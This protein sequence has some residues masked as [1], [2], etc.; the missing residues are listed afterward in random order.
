MRLVA[1]QCMV[2]LGFAA[3]G[4]QLLPT[5]DALGGSTRSVPD[6]AFANT[7]ALH[8]LN[9]V[10]LLEPYLWQ[11]RVVG[12]N[13]HELGLYVGAVPILLCVWL[14][15]R[16]EYPARLLPF[17]RAILVLAVVSLLLAFG[18]AG[19]LYRLQ[20]L[21]P[22]V[23]QFRFP[24]RAIVLF[25]LCLAAGAATALAAMGHRLHGPDPQSLRRTDRVLAI[26]V[27][28]SVALAIAGPYLWPEFV[29]RPL[30]IWCG[31]ALI[32][33][34]AILIALTERRVRGAFA[35]LAI[36]TVAD[37]SVYGLSYSVWNH[38]D[39]LQSFI[40]ASPRPPG[41]RRP[42]RGCSRTRQPAARA[43]ACCCRAYIES[44]ATR[45]WNPDKRL[46]YGRLDTLRLAGASFL[47]VPGAKDDLADT[48]WLAIRSPAPR[49]RLFNRSV[50]FR[51]N[52]NVAALLGA[53]AAVDTELALPD[54]PL[55]TVRVVSD[56]P[57]AITLEC[58][59]PARQLLVTTES[60]H[61][62]WR[63][64]VDGRPQPVL[65]VNADFLGCVVE[66]GTHEVQLQFR[67]RSLELGMYLSAGGLGLLWCTFAW[68]LRRPGHQIQPWS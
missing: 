12:Q 53:T 62:G 66:A 18:D 28:A 30:L 6:A 32:G 34:A 4:V 36:F 26:A 64:M 54:V 21:I 15:A 33:A 61:P 63:A 7:G 56:R 20:G 49:A 29:A 35:L 67:P 16:R 25:Q 60:F 2:L 11:T 43:T 58:Q 41:D 19:I 9:L 23:S 47:M 45:D 39:D 24:C 10:Q 14:A 52:L 37:L 57:G 65:P 40:A 68:R 8:P 55:G 48:R 51:D 50:R 13:T 44:T 1:V 17:V 59:T 27:A 38:T 42:A 3:A 5:I 46:D 31:P 22:L